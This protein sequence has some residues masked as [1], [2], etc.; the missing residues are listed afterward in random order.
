M[1]SKQ[2]QIKAGVSLLK[3]TVWDGKSGLDLALEA[4]VEF[5]APAEQEVD[6]GAEGGVGGQVQGCQSTLG[7]GPHAAQQL[8][9]E[10]TAE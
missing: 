9:R 5:G 3:P 10:K 1:F 8:L 6:A 2:Y 4:V 7:L